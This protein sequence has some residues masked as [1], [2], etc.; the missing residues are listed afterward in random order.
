M[1]LSN[2]FSNAFNTVQIIWNNYTVFSFVFQNLRTIKFGD[3][4]I[5]KI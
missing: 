5:I 4:T 3:A 1:Y 2:N